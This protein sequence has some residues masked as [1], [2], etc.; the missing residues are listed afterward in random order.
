MNQSSQGL[1]NELKCN[2][3]AHEQPPH[4]NCKPHCRFPPKSSWFFVN[5]R[6]DHPRKEFAECAAKWLFRWLCRQH[7]IDHILD[8]TLSHAKGFPSGRNYK[9]KQTR[10]T[11]SVW[12]RIVFLLLFIWASNLRYGPKYRPVEGHS[13]T[14]FAI[15]RTRNRAWA[16][17]M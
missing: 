8:S 7:N 4:C 3:A 6:A 5:V 14:E 2:V 16:T 17:I 10:G 1:S 9:R 11:E 15:T 12:I 13:K